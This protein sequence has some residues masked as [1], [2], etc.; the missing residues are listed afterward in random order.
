MIVKLKQLVMLIIILFL[1]GCTRLTDNIDNTINVILKDNN[2]VVNTAGYGFMYYCP[3][4][5]RPVFN[6]NNN[7]I[8]KIKGSEVYFYV[9]II[10]Y[11]YKTENYNKDNTYNYY[12]KLLNYNNKKGFIGINKNTDD[13]FIEILYDY[14]KIEGYANEENFKEVLANM[15]IILN[16]IKYNDTMIKSLLSEDGLKESEISYELDKPESAESNFSQY[17]QE[18]VEEED[19]DILPD[20]E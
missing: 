16:N 1:T 5:V 20:I 10:G 6:E 14:A 4:G 13:Y 12:Y 19:K 11:Y 18:I 15:L 3:V 7:L 17:L 9:D 2:I 8:L